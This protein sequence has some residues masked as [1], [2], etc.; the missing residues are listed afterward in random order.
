MGSEFRL[1]GVNVALGPVTAPLG[2]VVEGRAS[3]A[4]TRKQLFRD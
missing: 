1:K 4:E 2:R 3:K